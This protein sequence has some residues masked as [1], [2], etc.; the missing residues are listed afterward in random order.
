M[1]RKRGITSFLC[2]KWTIYIIGKLLT[3]RLVLFSDL[4][5]VSDANKVAFI[6]TVSIFCEKVVNY[7]SDNAEVVAEK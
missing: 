7:P 6:C 2:S 5:Q 4:K 3:K 1:K